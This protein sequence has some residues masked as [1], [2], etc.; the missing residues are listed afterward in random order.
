MISFLLFFPFLQLRRKLDEWTISQQSDR[1]LFGLIKVLLQ[2]ARVLIDYTSHPSSLT[3]IS[4]SYSISALS[5]ICS[6]WF[7]FSRMKYV[8]I[9]SLAPNSILWYSV[10]FSSM[11]NNSEE[12]SSLQQRTHLHPCY[13]SFFAICI[14]FCWRGHCIELY[15]RHIVYNRCPLNS[16]KIWKSY[17][18]L[19]SRVVYVV[20]NTW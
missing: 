13:Y 5:T 12:M 8:W 20:F 1:A 9:S 16:S 18:A 14:T 17:I 6:F 2:K 10:I 15:G 3:T 7:F 4:S 19:S 11:S